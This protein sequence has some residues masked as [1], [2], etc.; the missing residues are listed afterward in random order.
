M[1]APTTA[2]AAPVA[3]APAAGRLKSALRSR[4]L[5]LGLGILALLVLTALLGPLFLGDPE[6]VGQDLGQAPSG[7]HWLGTTQ[8]GQDVFTQF[9]VAA[10]GTLLIGAAAALI[11]TAVS[12][13]IGIGGGFLGGLT[14]EALSLLSN[15]FLVIPGLP[16]VIV[17]AAYVGAGTGSTILVIALTTWAASARVLRAQTL[18]LR[19][20]DYVLAARLYGESRRRIVLVEILPNELA[21]VVSQFIFAVIFAVLT[22]AALAF[23]GLDDPSNL[24][25]G[26][27]LYFAQNAE[28]LAGGS[29]WWFIPPGLAIAVLGAAL[30]LISFGLDE[31]LDPRLRARRKP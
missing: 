23:L 14:D 20:R 29:W 15:I 5:R 21:I 11:A 16:L 8:T 17:V 24:T 18:S 9:V 25:W 1:T 28:A 7:A 2:L 26:T 4:R 27:M 13:V 22:Q 10:R 31:I 3:A 6:A 30:S 19:T 12:V